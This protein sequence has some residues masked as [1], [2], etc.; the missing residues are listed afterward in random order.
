MLSITNSLAIQA[1]SSESSIQ[2][3]QELQKKGAITRTKIAAIGAAIRTGAAKLLNALTNN[4]Q[5]E[6]VSSHLETEPEVSKFGLEILRAFADN[7][8]RSGIKIKPAVEIS[9]PSIKNPNAPS[10]IPISP[11][12]EKTD[13]Y[14]FDS[15]KSTGSLSQSRLAFFGD[16]HGIKRFEEGRVGIAKQMNMKKGDIVVIEGS[17]ALKCSMTADNVKNIEHIKSLANWDIEN[18][19]GLDYFGWDDSV[20]ILQAEACIKKMQ[21]YD[22]QL[23]PLISQS[24]ISPTHELQEK[25]SNLIGKYNKL[26][27]KL[28]KLTDTERNKSLTKQ[29]NYLLTTYPDKKILVVLGEKHLTKDVFEQIQEKK[30]SV[31]MTAPLS[32]QDERERDAHVQKRLTQIQGNR[33][34]SQS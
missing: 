6:K 21:D 4:T 12:T 10:T 18:K 28:K 14:V 33:S 8:I 27:E 23:K 16:R 25:I 20:I 31:M 34:I 15:T 2:G 5:A 32:E 24:E 3:S 13:A 22:E 30:Y 17:M 19:I 9:S 26:K 7:G 1:P 11:K 29:I